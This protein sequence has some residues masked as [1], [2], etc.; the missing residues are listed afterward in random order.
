MKNNALVFFLLFLPGVGAFAQ[1]TAVA[2]SLAKL[3]QSAEND[4]EKVRLLTQLSERKA[5]Y[6]LYA[7]EADIRQMLAVAEKHNWKKEIAAAHNQI[8]SLHSA[9]GNFKDAVKYVEESLRIRKE[10]NDKRGISVSYY[11][12]ASIYVKLSDY[13]KGID[14]CYKSLSISER[15][16]DKRRVY[17]TYGILGDLFMRLGDYDKA[18]EW[19][20]KALR[21]A[22]DMGNLSDVA[23]THGS[24]ALI[25]DYKN[26]Y[27]KAIE[28]FLKQLS[29]SQQ[30]GDKRMTSSALGNLGQVYIS[31][32]DFAAALKYELQALSMKRE[33]GGKPGICALL[34]NIGSIYS[35]TGNLL[36]AEACATEALG[37]ARE[38]RLPDNESAALELLSLVYRKKGD[39]EKAFDFYRQYI[40]I[41]DSVLNDEK[42]SEVM[43]KELQFE[44]G[45]KSIADSVKAAEEKKYLLQRNQIQELE[46]AQNRYFIFGLVAV[47]LFLLAAAFLILRQN[48]LR[49]SQRAIQLEQKL[50]RSQ[51]NPHFIFNSLTAIESFIY[52]KQPKEAGRYLSDFARLMRL[53]LENSAEEYITLEKEL[54]TLGYYLELQKLRLD[55][56][57]NYTIEVDEAIDPEE[58][59]IPPMLTQP[60]IENAI[61][62]GIGATGAKGN[63]TVSFRQDKDLLIVEVTDDG[64][65][66][67]KATVQKRNTSHK[68]FAM[69]ITRERLEFLNRLAKR[70]LSFTVVDLSESPAAATGTKVTF[71]IPV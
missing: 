40:R 20:Q 42:K 65:G 24:I 56:Q 5:A 22:S 14:Y 67:K 12:L 66:I 30:T 25:Y 28:H 10:I 2:D 4:S 8:G 71:E 60:F 69:Q 36:K 13:T 58:I 70:K 19:Q 41:R 48:R 9:R 16:G 18:M 49:A 44:F 43:R 39:P 33:L 7:A 15:L 61:E 59:Y 27:A 55:D 29:F 34:I 17:S 26:E 45:K 63:L 62:H 38:I 50:L 64:I 31:L 1:N 3:V 6:D 54:K 51:M 46:I 52:E 35:E 11:S 47:I 23:R 21:M 53:I 37:L 68:S 32:G 57:L